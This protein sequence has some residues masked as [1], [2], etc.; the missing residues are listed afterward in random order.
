M[1]LDMILIALLLGCSPGTDTAIIETDPGETGT[2]PDSV[3]SNY[4][5]PIALSTRTP[6]WT[7]PMRA[8][9]TTATSD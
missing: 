1:L 2:V 3:Q 4:F 7:G 5:Q 6:C 9:A 8:R